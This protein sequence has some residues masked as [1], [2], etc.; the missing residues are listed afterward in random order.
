MV[1]QIRF[2]G[3]LKPCAGIE[4]SS[5]LRTD[6]SGWPKMTGI[7]PSSKQILIFHNKYTT[8]VTAT[9]SFLGIVNLLSYFSDDKSALAATSNTLADRRHLQ[10][11]NKRQKRKLYCLQHKRRLTCFACSPTKGSGT[12]VP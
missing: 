9:R 8:S 4:C 5:I 7:A 1:S 3:G 12:S 6:L 2:T 11:Q 10:T